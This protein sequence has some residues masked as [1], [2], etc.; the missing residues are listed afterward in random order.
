MKEIIFTVRDDDYE[1]AFSACF[2]ALK[3]LEN[4]RFGMRVEN[5]DE[6]SKRNIQHIQ[7]KSDS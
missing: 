7:P 5:V 2:K 1:R 3:K 4:C 6:N